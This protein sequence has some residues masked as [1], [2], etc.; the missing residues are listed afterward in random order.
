[1]CS[2][3][4]DP[5]QH[6]GVCNEEKDSFGIAIAKCDCSALDDWQGETCEHPIGKNL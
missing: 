5:C 2:P 6:G 4:N 3:S 1:M